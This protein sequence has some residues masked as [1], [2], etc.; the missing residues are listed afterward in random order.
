[1]LLSACLI[2]KNEEMTLERCLQSLQGIADE[3]ILVDTGSTDRTVAIAESLGAKV[4]HY[5]WDQDFSHARNE[6]LR[7]ASG[8]W[9]LV[10]DADEYL[11][12]RQKGNLRAFLETAD[13]EGVFVT[14]RNYLGSIGHIVNIMPIRVMRLFRRGHTYSGA[15]HEQVADSVA[16]TKRPI[17]VF[18]LNLHHVGYTN[19]FVSRKAKSDRNTKLIEEAL[20]K[21]PTNVFQRSNL[22]AEYILQ[23]EYEKCETLAQS[24]WLS[25]KTTPQKEWPNFAARILQ[26][27]M[28]ALWEQ[29][30][31]EE[32]MERIQE[33]VRYF[34][35]FTDL[36]KRYANML[37]MQGDLM[38]AER[39]L[40]ECRRQGDT[41]DGL[42]EV[43]EGMGTYLAAADLGA[44][45]ALLGDDMVARKWYLQ[46]FLEN[47]TLESTVIPLVFLF[48]P[49]P[50]FLQEHIESRILDGITYGNY[51]ETY[52]IRGIPGAQEVIERAEQRF[53]VSEMTERAKAAL[54]RRQGT[55]A[56]RRYVE[57]KGTENHWFWL[58]LH[59]LENEGMEGASEAFD[60]AG[61]RGEYMKK[62]Y[63]LLTQTS[64]SNWGIRLVTRDLVAMSTQNLLRTWLPMATDRDE[65]WVYLKYSPLGHVLSEIEWSGHTVHECEQNALRFFRTKQLDEAEF[66]LRSAEAFQP[67]VTQVLL[68]C[69]IALARGQIE[70]AGKVVLE[71]KKRFPESEFV[72]HASEQ[73]HPKVDSAKL[74]QELVKTQGEFGGLLS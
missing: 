18:D 65:A 52:A 15:I 33:G 17:G 54:L 13:A 60:R 29:G 56:L 73:V 39:V 63:E 61:T 20:K 24:T 26:H 14:Q 46:S 6:S 2:A 38:G 27:L 47:P 53:G 41:K 72:K 42:I 44:V 9:I 4:F 28:V 70:L 69:D 67:T 49:E 48:P 58:G 30:K 12:E 35:W 23:K 68:A 40:M 45:W 22:I 16:R 11:D 32:A 34:P 71:G 50:Q 1:M 74:Y 25:I 43:S 10:I 64:G 36:K 57:T 31:R 21:D 3:V 5:E 51:A 62:V 59:L 8:D 19:E 55:E 66:W 37:A 7:H